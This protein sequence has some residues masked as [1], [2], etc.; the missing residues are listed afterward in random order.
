MLIGFSHFVGLCE[1]L[2]KPDLKYAYKA[3]LDEIGTGDVLACEN[4]TLD[5]KDRELLIESLS[6]RVTIL[7]FSS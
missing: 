7:M 6:S 4:A 5:T 3:S 2:S 1:V